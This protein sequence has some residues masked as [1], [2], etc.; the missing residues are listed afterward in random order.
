MP[1]PLHT[2]RKKRKFSLLLVSYNEAEHVPRFLAA[3]RKLTRKPDE[4][5][6]VDS[7]TDD[8]A[9]LLKP[10][11]TKLIQVPKSSCGHA[12]SVGVPQCKGDVVVFTDLDAEPR[13]DWLEKIAAKFEDNPDVHAVVGTV[14]FDEISPMVPAPQ[15]RFR[16]NGCNMAYCRHV[17][18]KHPFD[19]WVIWDDLDLGY[20]VGK[21]FII[22]GCPEA[23]TLHHATFENKVNMA[24]KTG[25][26]WLRLFIKYRFHPFWVGRFF[27]NFLV[28]LFVRLDPYAA[29]LSLWSL[30]HAAHHEF[31][32]KKRKGAFHDSL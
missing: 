8:T 14:L 31:F 20:R 32:R 16:V 12:R 9:R 18:D 29:L 17:L 23:K 22:Y 27:Y 21:E 26:G 28:M 1:A 4:V 15:S 30:L 24:K 6:L 10:I 5:V 25:V 13:P 19:P 3:F 11:L 7:S 2:A